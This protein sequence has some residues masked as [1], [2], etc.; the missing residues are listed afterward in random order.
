MTYVLA[1]AHRATRAI[2]M[3]RPEAAAAAIVE[4]ITGPLLENPQ[5][6]G[7]A[8]RGAL[9]GKYGARRGQY[10]VV[11]QIEEATATVRVV[12]IDHRS[13]AYRPS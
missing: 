13:D 12:R 2:E 4:F 5:R 3:D 1:L 8:L 10:R 6:V 7:R 9:V 11:Y